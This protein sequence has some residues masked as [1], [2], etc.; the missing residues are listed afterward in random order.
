ME[1]SLILRETGD[2]SSLTHAKLEMMLEE[3]NIHK[4][5]DHTSLHQNIIMMLTAPYSN[6]WVSSISLP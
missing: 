6:L 3:D 1:Y 2:Y 4:L 5:I